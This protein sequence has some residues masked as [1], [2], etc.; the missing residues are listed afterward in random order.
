MTCV[1]FYSPRGSAF[2]GGLHPGRSASSPGGFLRS[3]GS[4]PR[5]SASRGVCIKGKSA[6]KWVGDGQIPPSHTMGYGQGAGGMYLT[7][8]HSSVEFVYFLMDCNTL[9]FNS[10]PTLIGIVSECDAHFLDETFKSQE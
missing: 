9:T 4:A 3:G 6:Y 5:G 1:S 10:A 7:G 2:R 8:M